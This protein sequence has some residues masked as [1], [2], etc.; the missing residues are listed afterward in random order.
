M[1]F[2]HKES[3]Y[4]GKKKAKKLFGCLAVMK[5]VFFDVNYFIDM[6]RKYLRKML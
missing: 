4:P 5:R 2:L 1:R 3:V 6:E